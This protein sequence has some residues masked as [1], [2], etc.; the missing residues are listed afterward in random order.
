MNRRIIFSLISIASVVGMVGGSALA[1]F[2]STASNNGNTFGAGSLTLS[3]NTAT[4][5]SSTPVFAV[6]NAAPGDVSA[7]QTLNLK[8]EGSV[9]ANTV[10]LTGIDLGGDATLANNLVLELAVD[11]NGNGLIDPTETVNNQS[12]SHGSW[13]G[14]VLG[15]PLAG[16]ASKPVL[17]RITFDAGA[18]NSVQGTS[19]SFNFNFQASQ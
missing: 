6:T 13:T 18:P 2:T 17:A 11:N 14:L 7:I 15:F 3:I 19:A 12:L 10:T 9:L 4:G 16:G 5:S 1:A 8:N